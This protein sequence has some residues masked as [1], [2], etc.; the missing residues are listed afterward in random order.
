MVSRFLLLTRGHLPSPFCIPTIF[1]SS[2]FFPSAY[3]LLFLFSHLFP[4]VTSFLCSPF[5]KT[6]SEEFYIHS[7]NSS[8]FILSWNHFNGTWGH[9]PYH[10]TKT[11]L[12]KVTRDFP[13]VKSRGQF[14]L[15]ILLDL[16]VV[17]TQSIIHTSMKHLLYLASGIYYTLPVSLSFFFADSSSQHWRIQGIVLGGLAH[18]LL[19]LSSAQFHGLKCHLNTALTFLS[20]AQTSPPELHTC[21][22][23]CPLGISTC[24]LKS[25][26]L[27]SPPGQT[28]SHSLAHLS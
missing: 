11:A 6:S 17:S 5:W 26:L 18:P 16:S 7:W 1:F 19:S 25:E 23:N 4:N 13:V 28:W 9:S 2:G 10:S 12:S 21:I 15:L 8:P 27:I 14:P 20:L 22:S 3:Q 24:M